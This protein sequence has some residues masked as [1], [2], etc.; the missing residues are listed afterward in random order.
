MFDRIAGFSRIRGHTVFMP[1]LNAQSLVVDAGA[2]RGEFSQEIHQRTGA[3][4]ILIE[5][6][7]DLAS[8][9]SPPDKGRAI[10]AAL[11][12]HDGEEAFVFSENMEAGSIALESKGADSVSV[13][14]ISLASILAESGSD[15]ISLLKLDIEGAEFPL[16]RETPD[17]VWQSVDQIT[18]EFHDFIPDFQNKGLVEE[19]I[20]RLGSLGFRNCNM[21]FRTHGDVIF[22]RDRAAWTHRKFPLSSRI[23]RWCLKARELTQNESR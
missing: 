22:L 14:T 1:G 9:L 13:R 18:I 11:S 20:A 3:R 21:A 17:E 8:K 4:C 6:H 5:P 19:S 2:H 12:A 7:P 23:A 10:Q 16:I 15:R